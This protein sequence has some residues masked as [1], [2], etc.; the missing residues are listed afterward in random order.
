VVITPSRATGWRVLA[1]TYNPV[2]M[3][4][5]RLRQSSIGAT[6]GSFN[7]REITIGVLTPMPVW[8]RPGLL[9]GNKPSKEFE[10]HKAHVFYSV[11]PNIR[12]TI[13]LQDG[14]WASIP[15][16][17]FQVNH[18]LYARGIAKIAYCDGVARFGLHEFRALAMVD[19]ILGRYP[20]VPYFVGCRIDKSPPPTPRDVLHEITV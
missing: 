16:P 19:L 15:F 8:G 11:P 6:N 13:S 14:E 1:A 20:F 10:H 7:L 9:L 12:E 18:D 2:E 3:M 17:E 5:R 4:G